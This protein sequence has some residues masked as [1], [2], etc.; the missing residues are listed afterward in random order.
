MITPR[1]RDALAFIFRYQC[2]H[3]GTAPSVV[4]IQKALGLSSKSGV[5]RLLNG[6]EERGVLRRLRGRARS[7]EVLRPHLVPQF[8]SPERDGLLAALRAMVD[9]FGAGH[10]DA[11]HGA[12]GET[13]ARARAEIAKAERQ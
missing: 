12:E 10:V 8:G 3:S 13:L 11:Y 6:L 2:A 7:I 5:V 1:Q 4:E 9:V